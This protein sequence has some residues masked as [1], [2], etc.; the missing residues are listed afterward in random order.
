MNVLMKTPT[1]VGGAI[2]PDACPTGPEG[3]IPVGGVVVAKMPF[4]QDF[5]VQISAV[6]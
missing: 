5:I 4:I 1:L 3:Q 2:M 6:L